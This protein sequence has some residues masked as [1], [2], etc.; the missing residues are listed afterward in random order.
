MH[1][2]DE[3]TKPHNDFTYTHPVNVTSAYAA[4]FIDFENLFYYLN[5]RIDAN[6]DPGDCVLRMIRRLQNEFQQ[7]YGELCI[8]QHAYAD[9]EKLDDSSQSDLY[10]TGIE[11]HHVLG[12]EHKNAADM[13][14][15]ID[16]MEVMYTRPEIRSFVF[17]AGDRDYIPV[18]QHLKKHART[19]RAAAFKDNMSGDL[20]RIVG[21]QNFIDCEA[22]LPSGYRLAPKERPRAPIAAPPPVVVHPV[23]SAPSKSRF[24]S[25]SRLEGDERNAM[26]VMLEHFGQKPEVWMTPYLRR[27]REEMPLL[28]EYQRKAI[29]SQLEMQGACAVEKRPGEPNPYSVIVINWNHPDVKELNP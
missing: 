5:N 20:L 12:T 17:M 23:A 10:L 18:I 11:T 22:L 16:A 7:T 15:C 8:V 28:E 21:E 4:L 19:V 3:V 2:D 9:F 13:R 26:R 14:L 6:Q 29:I 25:P 24:S 1:A 27:L